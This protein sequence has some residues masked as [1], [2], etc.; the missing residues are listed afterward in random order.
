MK[1]K[2]AHRTLLLQRAIEEGIVPGGGTAFVN[3]I[4]VND[5]IAERR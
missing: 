1:K 3:V 5:L 4:L 2:T